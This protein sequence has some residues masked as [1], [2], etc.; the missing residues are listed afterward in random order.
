MIGPRLRD[1]AAF[2][3]NPDLSNV[4]VAVADPDVLE[5]VGVEA[6]RGRGARE[7]QPRARLPDRDQVHEVR[8]RLT[9]LRSNYKTGL[10]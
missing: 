1:S 10:I 9:V 4:S 3:A 8:R 6:E 7:L 5:P 2:S